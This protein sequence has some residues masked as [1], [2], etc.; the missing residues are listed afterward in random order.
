MKDAEIFIR[1]I[2]GSLQAVRGNPDGRIITSN[3]GQARTTNPT[4]A[5]DG[6]SV[7]AIFDDLGRQLTTPYQVRDLVATAQASTATLA[8]VTLLAGAASTFHD[9][10]EITCA[11]N[12]GAAVR[13]S[14]RDATAAGVVKTFDVPANN[15]IQQTFPVPVP[16]NTAAAAWTIQNAGSG[17]ISG[18][19]VTVSATFVKNV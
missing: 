17:D 16:Q 19:D 7:S 12:T 13:V 4:A 3:E 2:Q 10:L 11:N 5:S 15:T 8:E 14:L 6:A 18:T 9:L 1:D